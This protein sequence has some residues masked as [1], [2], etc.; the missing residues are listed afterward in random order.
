MQWAAWK[1]APLP[2]VDSRGFGST[3]WRRASVVGSQSAQFIESRS[4]RLAILPQFSSLHIMQG[5]WSGPPY[6][7]VECSLGCFLKSNLCRHAP[8]EARFTRFIG[9]RTSN[10]R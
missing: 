4:V 2:E 8:F 1:L 7:I 6:A 3:Q 10:E 9:G 5:L